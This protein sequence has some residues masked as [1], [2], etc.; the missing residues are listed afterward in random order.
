MSQSVFLSPDQSGA[1]AAAGS[2]ATPIPR[3][4][5]V[6]DAAKKIVASVTTIKRLAT[7]LRLNVLQTEGGM[8]ILTEDQVEKIKQERER[9]LKEAWR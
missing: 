4:F 7:E 1:T 5:T 3:I 9:R 6:G 2:T 8:W